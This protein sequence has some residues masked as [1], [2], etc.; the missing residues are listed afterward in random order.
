MDCGEE[1]EDSGCGRVTDKPHLTPVSV[2]CCSLARVCL[3]RRLKLQGSW[4]LR[5]FSL[6]TDCPCYPRQS[7]RD[8]VHCLELNNDLAQGAQCYQRMRLVDCG[9]IETFDGEKGF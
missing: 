6:P 7:S 2:G 9:D 3:A 8:W 1:A 5:R 4:T